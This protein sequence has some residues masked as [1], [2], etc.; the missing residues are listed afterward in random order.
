MGGC[1]GVAKATWRKVFVYSWTALYLEPLE[2]KPNQNHNKNNKRTGI[3]NSLYGG[4]N[5]LPKITAVE[6]AGARTYLQPLTADVSL[7]LCQP[8]PLPRC[9]PPMS[10]EAAMVGSEKA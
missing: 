3:I 4:D 1:E 8:S 9:H 10:D 7:L 6:N 2:T 5:G